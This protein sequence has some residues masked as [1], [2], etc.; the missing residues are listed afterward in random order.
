M[1][2]DGKNIVITGASSGIGKA[3]LYNL[4][5]YDVQ[6]VVADL[7]PEKINTRTGKVF[8]L[9]C[10]LSKKENVD[11]LFDFALNKL[12]HIDVFVANAGFAY[13]EE[14]TEPDWDH[15]T[16]ILNVDFTSPIYSLEKMKQ[17]N[18]GRHYHF[19]INASAI[20]K[21]GLPGYA[22]YAAAKA[23]LDN[24]AYAYRLE[25]RDKGMLTLVYPIA[26]KTEFY[27]TAGHEV[28]IPW[29][30]Q[31]PET[32]AKAIIRGI[33]KDKAAIFPS[34]LFSTLLILDRLFPFILRM[35]ALVQQWKFRRWLRS[36]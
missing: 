21:L 4:Q 30:A 33:E 23:A 24:F 3:L 29:P 14:L 13:Y 2:L 10:D 28:P 8:P 34:R 1:K 35:Y 11:K 36:H 6:I 7:E 20:A 18:V 12:G 16:N 22:L 25:K 31:K 27:K 15:I 9:E 19:V 26:T 17:L 5:S 32:V